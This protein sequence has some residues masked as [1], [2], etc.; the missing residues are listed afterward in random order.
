MQNIEWVKCNY[1]GNSYGVSGGAPQ[2]DKR[3]VVPCGCILRPKK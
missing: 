3:L 2:Y 1:C